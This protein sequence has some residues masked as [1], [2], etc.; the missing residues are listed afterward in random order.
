MTA[1]A[2]PPVYAPASLL[3]LGLLVVFSSSAE[4]GLY[5][6][7]EH[8]L[9]GDLGMSAV[10]VPASVRFPPG[11]AFGDVTRAQ[12]ISGVKA[13]KQTAVGFASNQDSE[14]DKSK[15]GVQDNCYW[16]GFGQRKYDFNIWIPEQDSVPGRVLTVPGYATAGAATPFTFGELVALYG[17][18]RRAPSCTGG[19]C[20][21][22]H[23]DTPTLNFGRGTLLY[24]RYC[25]ASMSMQDYLRRIASGL[26]P[27]FGGWGN[28]VQ[29]TANDREFGE[30][31]WWGDE[32]MRIA[33][34]ND[35]HFSNVAIAWYT[36]MHRLALAAVDSARRDPTYWITALHYEASALHSLTDVFAL[37]HVVTNR[38]ESSSGM[39]Q[40]AALGSAPAYQWME[41]A[42][43]VGG[44]IRATDGVVNLATPLP[45]ITAGAS[46]R[47]AVLLTYQKDWWRWSLNEHTYH[48]SFNESGAQVRN[49]NGDVFYIYGDSLLHQSWGPNQ[50]AA[51]AVEA[52]RASV[53]SL[54]DAY[55]RLAAGATVADVGKAGS[56]FFAALKLV[57]V[58]IEYDPNHY[59]WGRWALYAEF[60]DDVTGAGKVPANWTTCAIPRITGKSFSW[61]PVD[62]QACTTGPG[63]PAPR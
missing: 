22:T 2:L 37:G 39:I 29:N 24:R 46:P 49:L 54:F 30:A 34:V 45:A 14:Y 7:D 16:T 23:D 38:D 31:G 19:T 25:P 55:V 52:V 20:F 10:R 4:T 61:P 26:W 21:L 44:G 58:F 28:A 1:P 51:V 5:N 32:M 60:V 53:Q 6:S 18:Y 50:G 56:P 40:E 41:N 42:I 36:G 47:D 48:D 59:F 62:P 15:T 11:L 17:D 35:W 8:R 3:V 13:A 12:Y 43:G 33:N 9:I 63:A 57:P 27:P